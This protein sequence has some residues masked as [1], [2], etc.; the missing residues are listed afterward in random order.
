MMDRVAG[1]KLSG[2]DSLRDGR[3]RV[4]GGADGGASNG[5]DVGA[6]RGADSGAE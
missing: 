6:A 1:P 3:G 2:T 4:V 5:A